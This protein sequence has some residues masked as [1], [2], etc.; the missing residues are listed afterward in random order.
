M[1]GLTVQLLVQGLDLPRLLDQTDGF[2]VDV[3]VGLVGPID[4]DACK[5]VR[6]PVHGQ[7]ADTGH[8]RGSKGNMA[9]SIYRGSVFVCLCQRRESTFRWD[10][11]SK[12]ETWGVCL[13]GWQSSRSRML[14][15]THMLKAL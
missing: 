13:L 12:G 11:Q 7:H 4:S 9:A 1:R 2:A 15:C 14:L 5:Q 3:G 6:E 10:L 8:D